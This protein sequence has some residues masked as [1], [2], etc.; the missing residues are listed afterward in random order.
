MN[1]K[2]KKIN[3]IVSRLDK[4]YNKDADQIFLNE[5]DVLD[6]LKNRN[7][8]KKY[9][10]IEIKKVKDLT[11]FELISNSS[12]VDKKYEKYIVILSS[13][14]NK[15]H[16]VNYDLTFW[17]QALNLGIIKYITIFHQLY[18]SYKINFNPDTHSANVIN[19][20]CFKS[21]F[22][23]EEGRN[24]ISHS[25]FGREQC[26]SVY[27]NLFIKKNTKEISLDYT[28]KK[29]NSQNFMYFINS[30]IEKFTLIKR[31]KIEIAFMGCLFSRHHY[32]NFFL[33]YFFRVGYISY[34]LNP[35]KSEAI[36]DIRSRLD[37]SRNEKNFDE[38]DKYFFKLIQDLLPTIYIENFN[39][40]SIYFKQKL[41]N[42]KNLKIIISEKWFSSSSVSL[43]LSF[44]RLRSIRIYSLEHNCFYHPYVGSYLRYIL[45][46]S[47]KYLSLGWNDR[48]SDKILP[49]GSLYTFKIKRAKVLIY[50]IL[51]LAAPAAIYA[52]HYNASWGNDGRAL[53]LHLT[54]CDSF[55]S[56]LSDDLLRRV[57]YRRYPLN[58][59]YL[60]F[61]KE[62]YL[63][64]F[65]GKIKELSDMKASSHSTIS[66]S[67]LVVIDYVST[68]YLETLYS[69]IP[70]VVFFNPEIYFLNSNFKSFFNELISV[71]IFQTNPVEAAKFI[72]KIHSDPEVWWL[73]VKVQKARKLFLDKNLGGKD[74]FFNSLD[75]LLLSNL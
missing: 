17:R 52:M 26:F 34:S 59:E 54:F 13:R 60:Y 1:T 71:G 47:D 18:L 19:S 61:D 68:S 45:D 27:S 41:N 62:S 14:L 66:K 70:T 5:I 21:P 57:T 49:F 30:V 8:I 48:K 43:F 23:F 63:A 73:S 32:I 4:I 29:F 42:Y 22:D 36:L 35:G 40:Y 31:N 56:E 25:D 74:S 53:N 37:L 55:F 3:F 11:E 20:K 39:K 58:K 69:N 44:A 7:L 24:F 12:Y 50:E 65:L 38:F 72:S 2:F 75:K 67:K 64:K 51:Y 9:K 16:G 6:H 46:S 28:L 33:K 10:K 15:I